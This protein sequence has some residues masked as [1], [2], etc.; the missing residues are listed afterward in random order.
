M[1][2]TLFLSTALVLVPLAVSAGEKPSYGKPPIYV[3]GGGGG[4]GGGGAGGSARADS[5]ATATAINQNYNRTS[6]RNNVRQN[7]W[8]AQSQEQRQRATANN[9]GNH[10]TISY[11]DRLQAPGIAGSFSSVAGNPCERAPFG[12]GASF[13]GFGGLLQVPL[14]SS[15]CWTERRT[16][17]GLQ[18]RQNGMP[19]S[20][21]AL[22]AIYA[23]NDVATA[24]RNN[25]YVGRTNYRALR[26][27][28]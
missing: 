17:L 23:G 19:I 7:Q 13:P 6:V 5:R 2:K 22:I 9:A 4:G 27:K 1:L 10:Q 12:L 16:T 14:E 24:I 28:Y 8:Q 26:R 25:P 15:P 21:N 3:G 11:Q 20:E 18:L